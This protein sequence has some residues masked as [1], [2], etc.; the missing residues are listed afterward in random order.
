MIGDTEFIG[1]RVIRRLTGR[2]EEVVCMDI[3]PGAAS[4]DDLGQQVRVMRGDV[5]QFD[6]VMNAMLST[7]PS[8]VMH[9]S[10]FLGSEPAPHVA[11]KLNIVGMDNCFAAVRLCQVQRVVYASSMAVSGQQKDYGGLRCYGRGAGALGG[12]A[13]A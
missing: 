2:G 8:R 5:T 3:N 9:L 11:T 4:F 10:Y 13:E 12:G 7:K 1:T 6:D